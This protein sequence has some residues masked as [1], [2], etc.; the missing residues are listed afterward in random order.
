MKQ[1]Y[2]G[3]NLAEGDFQN[4]QKIKASTGLSMSQIIR[5]MVKNAT[6]EKVARVIKSAE[7]QTR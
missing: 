1:H 5:A 3:C 4:L 7:I 2:V 6:T